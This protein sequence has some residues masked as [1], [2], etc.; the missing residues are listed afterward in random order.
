MAALIASC[1]WWGGGWV[2]LTLVL[3]FH[4]PRL[5]SGRGFFPPGSSTQQ[6]KELVRDWES[7][8]DPPFRV[9]N[10]TACVGGP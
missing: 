10:L 6:R 1:S 4:W 2:N 7:G 9:G 8:Q 3:T 5:A